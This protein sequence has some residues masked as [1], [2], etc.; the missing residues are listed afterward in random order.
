MHDLNG[1]LGR[2]PRGARVVVHDAVT[3]QLVQVPVPNGSPSRSV[4]LDELNDAV[5]L[6][7][8]RHTRV[9]VVADKGPQLVGDHRLVWPARVLKLLGDGPPRLAR[10]DRGHDGDCKEHGRAWRPDREQTERACQPTA[11]LR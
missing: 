11:A 2:R 4:P 6:V 1:T 7:K 5:G 10:I 9:Q 3:A 8:I